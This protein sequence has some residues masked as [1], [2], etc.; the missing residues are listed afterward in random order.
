MKKQFKFYIDINLDKQLREIISDKY[1]TVERGIIS[2]ELNEM[3]RNWIADHQHTRINTNIS[4]KQPTPE[5]IEMQKINPIP[6]VSQ[7]NQ[8]IK[9]YL[10]TKYDYSPQQVTL[11]DIKESIS[12]IRGNDERTIQKWTKEL[13]KWKCLKPISPNSFELV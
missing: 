5:K 13:L 12:V 11:S 3:I 6:K 8:Q 4:T 10:R 7:L 2:H 1:H 9:E